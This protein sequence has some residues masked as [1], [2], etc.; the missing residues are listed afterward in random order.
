MLSAGVRLPAHP[1]QVAEVAHDQ[2]TNV[3]VLAELGLV[4]PEGAGE[5]E[6]DDGV[7][8]PGISGSADQWLGPIHP[9]PR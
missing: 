8:Y 4:G 1:T 2:L 6:E 5:L 9:A 7:I 3:E